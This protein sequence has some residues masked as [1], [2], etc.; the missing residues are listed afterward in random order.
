MLAVALPQTPRAASSKFEI[1]P[2]HMTIGFL[3]THVGFAKTFGL[4]RQ[5]SGSFVFDEEALTLGD[6]KVVVETEKAYLG[7]NYEKVIKGAAG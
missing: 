6:V 3:V 4:F 1:D 2:S 5:A 7:E